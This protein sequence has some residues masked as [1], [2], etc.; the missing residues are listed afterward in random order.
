MYWGIHRLLTKFGSPLALIFTVSNHP[1]SAEPKRV[2]G[3]PISN[4]DT[5]RGT[6][7][8]LWKT[9]GLTSHSALL[10]YS[11]CILASDICGILYN[12][13]KT[14]PYVMSAV[15]HFFG[16]I[17]PAPTSHTQALFLIWSA[18]FHLLD[19]LPVAYKRKHLNSWSKW[20]ICLRAG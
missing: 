9:D 6:P 4:R 10:H 14:F 20:T 15:P 13:M 11:A 3:R 2:I 5:M 17:I 19:G 1:C 12:Q 7:T 16:S 8:A 18:S